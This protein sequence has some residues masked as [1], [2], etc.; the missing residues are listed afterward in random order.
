MNKRE[1]VVNVPERMN[2]LVE[3]KQRNI[4]RTEKVVNAHERIHK[5]EEETSR[6]HVDKK[7]GWRWMIHL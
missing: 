3:L 1:K 4:N 6:V 5:I 7:K 2:R